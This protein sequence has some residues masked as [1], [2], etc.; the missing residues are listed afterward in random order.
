[1][2]NIVLTTAQTARG[3]QRAHAKTV[4]RVTT[5]GTRT[6]RIV[7]GKTNTVTIAL[8]PAG[9][10]LIATLKRLR[11]KLTLSLVV[12]RAHILVA[13]RTLTITANPK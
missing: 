7:A 4:S 2:T 12:G 8:N 5:V 3:G 6:V 9:R 13:T 11:V 1:L 10:K